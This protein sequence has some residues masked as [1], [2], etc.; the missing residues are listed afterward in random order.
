MML[1]DEG[2]TAVPAASRLATAST[3]ADS[4]P[5]PDASLWRQGLCVDSLALRQHIA[6]RGSARTSTA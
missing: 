4:F 1:L 2:G 3:G 5:R 6:A